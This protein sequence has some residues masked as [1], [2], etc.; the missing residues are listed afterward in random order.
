[1]LQIL[2]AVTLRKVV[3]VGYVC[4]SEEQDTFGFSVFTLLMP[5]LDL[6]QAKLSRREDCIQGC[7][8]W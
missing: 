7:C 6:Y 1:M 4:G 5:A 2:A 3:G 8:S